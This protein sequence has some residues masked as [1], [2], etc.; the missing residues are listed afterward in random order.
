ME[1]ADKS[2]E[3]V[4]HPVQALYLLLWKINLTIVALTREHSLTALEE[5]SL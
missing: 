4:R 3:L 5:V 1:G 2:T